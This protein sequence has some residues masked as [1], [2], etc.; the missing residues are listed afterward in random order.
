MTCNCFSYN[1]NSESEKESLQENAVLVSPFS[2][3]KVSIDYCISKVVSHLWDNGIITGGS[4]CGHNK[5][6]PNIIITND[7]T[8][9]KIDSIKSLIEEIDPREFDILQWQLTKL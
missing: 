3:Q 1:H 2:N 5:E 4:C 9:E 8:K 6:N 7:N